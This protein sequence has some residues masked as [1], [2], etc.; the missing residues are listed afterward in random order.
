MQPEAIHGDVVRGFHNTQF[1]V[2]IMDLVYPSEEVGAS[3]CYD[4]VLYQLILPRV[5]Q[6]P[7][8]E[9]DKEI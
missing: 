1:V 8:L 5:R 2:C 9:S 7:L 6:K 4:L 3:L